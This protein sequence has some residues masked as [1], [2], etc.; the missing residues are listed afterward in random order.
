[1]HAAFVTVEDRLPAADVAVLQLGEQCLQF[2]PLGGGVG[3]RASYS[4]SAFAWTAGPY[5]ASRGRSMSI[6]RPD[7]T[8]E[9]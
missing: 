2:R 1:M 8:D 4:A 3:V 6:R 7:R 5:F 9:S